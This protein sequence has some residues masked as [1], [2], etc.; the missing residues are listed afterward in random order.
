M[1]GEPLKAL[2]EAQRGPPLI[3]EAGAGEGVS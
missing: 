2:S 3:D 1:T